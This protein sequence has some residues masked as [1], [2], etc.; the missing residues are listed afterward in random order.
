M[1]NIIIEKSKYYTP[2]VQEFGLNSYTYSKILGYWVSK[3]DKLPFMESKTA[4][5]PT[6]KKA[7]VETGE[8]R[9]GE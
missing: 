3:E 2:K 7:D 4:I 1:E 5:K 8:D 9:K 6:T